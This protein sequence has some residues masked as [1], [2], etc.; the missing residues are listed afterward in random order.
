MSGYLPDPDESR[1]VLVGVSGYQTMP[2]LPAVAHNITDLAG[3][4]SAPDVWGLPPHN[5]VQLP[6]PDNLDVVMKTISA[7][8]QEANDTLLIYYAGHG[9]T[10][11]R[12]EDKLYL[13]LPGAEDSSRL[14]AALDYEYLRDVLLDPATPAVRRIVILDCCWAGRVLDGAMGQPDGIADATAVAGT[15]VLTA[16]AGTRPAVAPPRARHTAFTGNCWR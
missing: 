16:V 15:Y 13:T 8:A 6:D 12:R 14:H 10:H 9:L 2:P 4:L 3:L 7:A 1:A 11:P 5:C